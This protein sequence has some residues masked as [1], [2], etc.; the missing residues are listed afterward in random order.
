MKSFQQ[1]YIAN[2]ADFRRTRELLWRNLIRALG[3]P[4][5]LLS[6]RREN[7]IRSTEQDQKENA[8]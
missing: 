4:P 1:I 8:V 7:A 6:K 2:V 5:G 3:I